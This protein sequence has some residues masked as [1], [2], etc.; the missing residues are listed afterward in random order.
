MHVH[1]SRVFSSTQDK[2]KITPFEGENEEK[3]IDAACVSPFEE[4][5]GNK[6]VYLSH[7]RN[8]KRKWVRGTFVIGIFT[9]HFKVRG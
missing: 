2:I 6:G 8:A 3:V 5:R 4:S 7:K 9:I 1:T